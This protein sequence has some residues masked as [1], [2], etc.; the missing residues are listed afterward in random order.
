M[1]RRAAYSTW[2][3]GFARPPEPAHPFRRAAQSPRRESVP[4]CKQMAPVS[5]V[6]PIMLARKPAR[7]PG[8]TFRDHA[9]LFSYCDRERHQV[10]AGGPLAM[11]L[12]AAYKGR[13]KSGE[14]VV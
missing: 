3:S 4:F 8:P 10:N 14:G 1:A 5:H 11:R 6:L 2:R 9:L 7:K 13:T 12:H